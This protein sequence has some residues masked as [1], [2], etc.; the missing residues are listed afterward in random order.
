MIALRVGGSAEGFSISPYSSLAS[1]FSWLWCN[2]G[3]NIGKGREALM[4]HI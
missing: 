1:Y 4:M 2:E 3:L